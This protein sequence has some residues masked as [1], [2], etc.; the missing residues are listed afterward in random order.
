MY[1]NSIAKACKMRNHADLKRERREETLGSE[2]EENVCRDRPISASKILARRLLLAE[3][4]G[5]PPFPF[6]TV[7]F[8]HLVDEVCKH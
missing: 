7:K 5:R 6:N 4:C 8:N 3:A 1:S 2:W